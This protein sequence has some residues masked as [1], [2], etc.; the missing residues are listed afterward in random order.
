MY[1]NVKYFNCNNFV[2]WVID[3]DIFI[4]INGFDNKIIE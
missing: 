1:E 4:L 3:G 2:M